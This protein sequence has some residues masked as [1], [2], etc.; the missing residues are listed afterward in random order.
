[1]ERVEVEEVK[2]KRESKIF[3]RFIKRGI[4]IVC[5][6]CGLVLLSPILLIVVF[7]IKCESKG[8][9]FFTQKRIGLNGKF[10]YILKFR[11]MVQN[12]E[13]VLQELLKDKKYREEWY[14]KHKF[15][16]DPRIT[17]IGKFLRKTSLDEVPQF[18]NV[19]KGDMSLIGPRPL[20]EGELDAHNGNHKIYESVR[21]GISGWWAANG[22]S[23]TTYEERLSLE[24]YYVKNCSLLLDIK[25]ILKTIG[26]V[27][28]RKGAK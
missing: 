28:F 14:L 8:P 24:Y 23:D 22:R 7:L 21:P 2:G 18:I 3:Y 17:K 25:C 20:V 11:T 6:S 19:I 13:E 16:N 10:I 9:I 27:I 5:A 15:E 4:D 1:M 12:A 26:V